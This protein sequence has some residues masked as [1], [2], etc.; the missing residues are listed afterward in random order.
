MFET[1]TQ[2]LPKK[3]IILNTLFILVVA[4]LIVGCS[5]PQA[6]PFE[7]TSPLDLVGVLSDCVVVML[8]LYK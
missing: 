8:V 6:T 2:L 5:S 4:F 1:A 7:P 3:Y